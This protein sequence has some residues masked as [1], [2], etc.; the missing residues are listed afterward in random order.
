MKKQQN[1]AEFK[2]IWPKLTPEQQGEALQW[3]I[4]LI[5]KQQAASEAG[6]RKKGKNNR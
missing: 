2:T 4:N 1:V 5:A 6:S 3:V